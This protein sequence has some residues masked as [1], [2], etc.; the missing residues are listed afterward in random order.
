MQT[1]GRRFREAARRA[2]VRGRDDDYRDFCLWDGVYGDTIQEWG[3]SLQEER[4]R[5]ERR[6][7]LRRGAVIL[8]LALL[9]L[10]LALAL[11]GCG[12]AQPAPAPPAQIE[13]LLGQVVEAAGAVKVNLTVVNV[14][15]RPVEIAVDHV[16]L[17]DDG[18]QVYVSGASSHSIVDPQR[19]VP[20][21][22]TGQL[23]DGRRLAA[24][25]VAVPGAPAVT[26]RPSEAARHIT[27]EAP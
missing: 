16:L 24:V 12:A 17:V 11:A 10:F 25:V 1:A 26:L 6:R 14:G 27:E 4:E 8:L 19:A 5:R 3:Q 21:E 22:V 20:I 2:D 23:P 13:A 18:G 7:S 9:L 15:E